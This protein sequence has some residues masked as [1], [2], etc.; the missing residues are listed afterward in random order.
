[1]LDLAAT[2]SGRSGIRLPILAPARCWLVGAVS[3]CAAMLDAACLL[4]ESQFLLRYGP[5]TFFV[6]LLD[7]S[8]DTR[9]TRRTRSPACSRRCSRLWLVAVVGRIKGM[10]IPCML[11]YMETALLRLLGA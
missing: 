7:K 9:K 2:A 1:M 6:A 5:N 4:I 3:A 8:R 10:L 11:A